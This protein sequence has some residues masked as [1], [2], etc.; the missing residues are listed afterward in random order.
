M[1]IFFSLLIASLLF[2]Y[3]CET[4]IAPVYQEPDQQS[5]EALSGEEGSIKSV[6]NYELIPLPRRSPIFLDSIF[7]ITKTIVGEIGGQLTLER[8]YISDKGKLITMLVDLVIPPHCFTG[9][10]NITLNIER[11]FALVNCSPQM[12]FKMPLHLVQTFTG[13]DLQN[14]ET[15]EIDFVYIGKNG[16]FEHVDRTAIVVNKLLG[17]VTVLDAKLNHFSRYGWVRK[18]E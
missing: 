12:E 3:S 17:I 2:I 9:Q 15:E 5:V 18:S 8:L 11:D 1:K 6:I 7:S 10:R 16:R 14:Y 13:L 4:N